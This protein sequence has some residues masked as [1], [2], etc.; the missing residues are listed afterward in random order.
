MPT[1]ME[2]YLFDLNGYLLLKHALHA[3]EV[4]ALNAGIDAIPALEHDEWYGYVQAHSYTGKE[5]LNLQ[6]IYEAGEAFENL[7]DHPSWFEKVKYFV[8][9][10]D[11]FDYK[12]GPLFIDENF[13]NI[14]GPGQAIGL[15][16]GG[17]TGTKRTQY[18]FHNGHFQCGQVNI[19]IALTQIG[20]GDGATMVI[21]ASHK[22]NFQHPEFASHHMNSEQ[23][24]VDG[25]TG[26]IEVFMNPGDALLFVDA[27][28]HGSAERVNPGNRRIIVYRYGPSW[29]NFRH[30][31]QPSPE[32]LE[33]LTP[34]RRQ[35]VQPQ[36][37]RRPVHAMQ[38]KP[39]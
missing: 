22:A 37:L 16:S 1:D 36:T 17:H 4:A 29:G 20:P 35:I 28:S 21:P 25:L 2:K 11:T 12:H 10:E 32:L 8:G 33:R 30:G 18:R 39:L 38:K 14:R 9:G 24:S 7:I 27:I 5:G 13:A 23:A 6:Q 31:Y 26:A 34:Q 19:L 15:H 3:D